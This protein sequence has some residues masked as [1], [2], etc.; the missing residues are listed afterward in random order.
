MTESDTF[1]QRFLNHRRLTIRILEAFPEADLFSFKPPRCLRTYGEISNELLRLE[2]IVLQSAVY[3][4]WKIQNRSKQ[5]SSK[6]DLLAAFATTQIESKMLW[7]QL[8]PEQL[9]Q[10]GI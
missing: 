4:V 9:Y 5:P 8:T 10:I 3:G 7:L 1:W 2:A 6:K